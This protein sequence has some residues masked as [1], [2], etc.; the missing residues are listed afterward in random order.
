MAG[1]AY[2]VAYFGYGLHGFAWIVVGCMVLGAIAPIFA[3]RGDLAMSAHFATGSLFLVIISTSYGS[4]GITQA[5]YA[6]VYVVPL[7]AGLLGGVSCLAIWGPL[8][9]I[10]TL[11]MSYGG[12]GPFRVSMAIPEAFM[13][14]QSVFDIVLIFVTL[15]L[16]IGT[17]LRTRTL[18][19]RETRTMVADL[20]RAEG[21]ARQ[22]DQAKS[23]FLATMSHEI[24]TPMNGVL[25]MTDLLLEMPLGEQQRRFVEVIKTSGES[26]LSILNDIL[27]YSKI[28]AGRMDLE[29]T[30]FDL[31]GLV[32][33]AVELIAARGQ[34]QRL[35]FIVDVDPGVPLQ[36]IGDPT[37]LRQVL[38]NLL[39]NAVKF[40]SKGEVEVGVTVR[41]RTSE[42]VALTI[43]V[44]DTGVGIAPDAIER[45]FKPFSQA[46][47]SVARQYGGTGLGLAISARI[48]DLMGGRIGVDSTLGFGSTF[49]LE[50]ELRCPAHV[51][52]PPAVA[53]RR[54]LLV[55][56][57]ARRREA[58]VR[59]LTAAGADVVGCGGAPAARAAMAADRAAQPFDAALVV[60]DTAGDGLRLASTIADAHPATRVVVLVEW[61]H[62]VEDEV[63]DRL[64][65]AGQVA[66]PG[67]SSALVAAIGERRTV[68]A[69][70]RATDAPADAPLVLVVDDNVINRRVAHHQLARLGYR[71]IEAE[72]GRDALTRAAAAGPDAILMDIE[73]PVMDGYEATRRLRD[74]ERGR[75]RVPVIALTAH[76]IAGYRERVMRAGMDDYLTKPLRREELEAT[77]R[78]LLRPSDAPSHTA[79]AV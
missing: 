26:L 55:D 39:G 37:R 63:L 8:T 34:E 75:A 58:L 32:E 25:G 50:L 56:P 59:L 73:M 3:L 19:E 17:F 60:R 12:I 16:I 44:R 57:H 64:R 35:V 24:R 27:D 62:F 6:W 78:R 67:T 71:V 70:P 13:E 30:P 36:V 28:E 41:G 47:A 21:E 33:Q 2:T 10:G 14:T 5:G 77:L 1:L 11:T 54:V 68:A 4:G 31:R 40:T 69:A 45:L 53:G 72:N 52:P 29:S 15:G 7:I 51:A 38:M 46:D 42:S 65:L 9:L 79:L 22:A 66:L 20:E 76:A 74:A 61:G 43:A 18:A 48:V 49:R 23:A